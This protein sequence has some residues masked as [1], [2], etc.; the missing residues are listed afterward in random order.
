MMLKRM[1]SDNGYTLRDL[2][3]KVGFSAV[4]LSKIEHGRAKPPINC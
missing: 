3:A 2:A 4:Y 1:R